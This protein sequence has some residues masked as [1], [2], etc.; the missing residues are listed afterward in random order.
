MTSDTMMTSPKTKSPDTVGA[1]SLNSPVQEIVKD[2]K[3]EIKLYEKLCQALSIED[4]LSL[5]HKETHRKLKT[6][7][8]VLYWPS[9]YFGPVQYV[10]H[11]KGVFRRFVTPHD[12]KPSFKEASSP[13]TS[14]WPNKDQTLDQ[15]KQKVALFTET[16]PSI[17]IIDKK[18]REYLAR[19][20]GR[21]VRNMLRLSIPLREAHQPVF[22]FAEFYTTKPLKAMFFYQ[23]FFR[24]ISHSIDRLLCEEHLKNSIDLWIATFNSLQEPLAVFDE[25]NNLSSANRAFHI[26]L[27]KVDK[28]TI[29]QPYFQWKDYFFEKQSYP[30]NVK[31]EQYTIYHYVDISESLRIGNKMIQSIRLSALSQLGSAV[32]HQLNN[33]LTGVLSMAQLI[34]NSPELSTE[35]RQDMQDIV[36]SVSRSQEIIANLLRFSR[37]DP[38]LVLCDLNEV[39]QKT[40]PFLKSLIGCSD[41]QLQLNKLPL[42]V[43]VQSSL[44]QQ[45]VFNL[46][47]NA[48]QAVADLEPSL[49]QIRVHTQLQKN[50]AVLFVEDSGQGISPADYKN[51]FKPF[52]TTKKERGG[53]GLGL[54]IS[55]DIVQSFN[56]HLQAGPSSLGGA[57]FSLSLPIAPTNTT[58]CPPEKQREPI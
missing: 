32:A 41:L 45:V 54:N 49:R 40:M 29:Y 9:V 8:L 46:V 31:G 58:L 55:R 6:G 53:T 50:Q 16:K 38:H 14:R 17:D 3:T 37:M 21:P 18:D 5:L 28:E 36:E 25:K 33:P 30:V 12:Y 1:G 24:S 44:L 51:I 2:E 7:T 56:G 47:Q 35:M 19:S 20:L 11:A 4:F 42:K 22:L 34:L 27:D 52:F 39:V 57:C 10:C 13:A 43:K 15:Q 48:C 23:S 26:L